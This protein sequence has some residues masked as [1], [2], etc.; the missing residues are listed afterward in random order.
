MV[1]DM[2]ERAKE[3]ADKI[4]SGDPMCKF[5]YLD[6]RNMGWPMEWVEDEVLIDSDG[7]TTE[8]GHAVAEQVS[9]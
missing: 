1:M 5:M 2:N 4:N 7:R 3:I 8:L 9:K 6:R